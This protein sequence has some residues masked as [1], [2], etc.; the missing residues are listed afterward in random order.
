MK[1]NKTFDCVDMKRKIQEK[2]YADT[3]HMNHKEM[4]EYFHKR[5]VKSRFA[6]FLEQPSSTPHLRR[7]DCPS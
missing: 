6:S 1:K 4:I 5:I 7:K 3:C 2:L